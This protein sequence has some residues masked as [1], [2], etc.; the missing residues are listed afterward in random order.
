MPREHWE[1]QAAN[2]A[3]WA[4]TPGFD[5]YWNYG[6]RFFELLRRAGLRTLDLGCGEGRVSR[7]LGARGHT[8]TGLDASA[9]LLRL[10]RQAD[11]DGCYVLADASFLPFAPEAFDLVVA[12]NSLMDVD[13]MPGAV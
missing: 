2:W 9:S 3:E 6:P 5:S 4:R 7:D 10:A 8:V 1:A 12:Y 11:P 13:D